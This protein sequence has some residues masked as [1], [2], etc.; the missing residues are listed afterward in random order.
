MLL[1]LLPLGRRFLGVI[2]RKKV[3]GPGRVIFGSFTGVLKG[4]LKN[5]VFL[6]W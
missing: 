1:I 2:L 6:G 3:P 5:R 4:V